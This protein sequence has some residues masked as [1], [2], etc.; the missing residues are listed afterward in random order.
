MAERPR[1][2]A[3][4]DRVVRGPG[5]VE[6]SGW[7]GTVTSPAKRHPGAPVGRRSVLTV[8]VCWDNDPDHPDY[9]APGQLRLRQPRDLLDWLATLSPA[10]RARLAANLTDRYTHDDQ[11]DTHE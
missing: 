5:S 7:H 1:Q 11:G 10:E 6:R 8:E 4:G 3:R 2:L 9:L